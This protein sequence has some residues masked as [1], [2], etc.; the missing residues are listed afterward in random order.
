MRIAIMASTVALLVLG[1]GGASTPAL[2]GMDPGAQ[3]EGDAS[4]AAPPNSDLGADREATPTQDG[5][6]AEV[7]EVVPADAD[8]VEPVDAA[9]DVWVETEAIVSDADVQ[10]PVDT[11]ADIRIE[12]EDVVA[13]ADLPEDG[14][15]PVDGTADADACVAACTDRECGDDGCGG[16][17][18]ACSDGKVCQA[19]ACV[20]AAED[21]KACCGMAVC[22]FDSCGAQGDQTAACL[23]GCLNGKCQSCAPQ[24]AGKVCGDDGCGGDCGTCPAGKCEALTWT[25]GQACVSGACVG[26]LTAKSCDDGKDCTTDFCDPTAGCSS[27]LQ[28][29]QCLIDGTCHADG[30]ASGRCLQCVTAKS[31]TAWTYVAGRPCND[32]NPCTKG[33]ACQAGGTGDAGCAGT[34]YTCDDGLACTTDTCDGQGGCTNTLLP[35][36]C[37]IQGTCWGDTQPN[38][39]DACRVCATS[40]S[41]TAWSPAS[42]GTI[43]AA[44]TCN[45]ATFTSART[46]VA[47]QCSAGGATQSC[48]DGLACTTDSCTA[49]GCRNTLISGYCLIGG[50]CYGNLQANPSNP[51][52]RCAAATAP[53]SWSPAADGTTCKS[54]TCSGAWWTQ[55]MTCSS[56]QCTGG[57]GSQ[58]CDDGLSCTTDACSP[59]SGCSNTVQSDHCLIAG[60][61]HATGDGNGQCLECVPAVSQTSWTCVAKSCNDGNPGTVNDQC[62]TSAAGCSC[63]G[64]PDPCGAA[65]NPT[66]TAAAC[67]TTGGVS[68][69]CAS[70]AAMVCSCVAVTPPLCTTN[71][72]C[73]A[74]EYCAK[75][76][77]NCNGK[78][79][80]TARPKICPLIYAPVCG[81]DGKTYNNSC[82]AAQTGVDVA[83]TGACVVAQTCTLTTFGTC[84]NTSLSCQCCPAGGP[85][86]HCVCSTTCKADADC[87][88]PTRPTCQKPAGGT[89]FCAPTDLT[90]C[91]G[92]L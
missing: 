76:D 62:V 36:Y 86:E 45:G 29:G 77:G 55:A 66:C 21:H 42:D 31:T 11:P 7:H 92:C 85:F 51:C 89:G 81:C 67:T 5:V 26:N 8:L 20:C 56:G 61:C 65:L 79:S 37:D 1:C 32:G 90:C 27:T 50:T 3:G 54:G 40:G 70:N 17:C 38:P 69:K 25:P 82:N 18:G 60:A 16:T 49:A 63:Q 43:C 47:G 14:V 24:C 52:Q 74:T 71:G 39:D 83:S 87:T 10:E 33:D 88:D 35:G 80:C 78:G 68:G 91:W 57:G 6:S 9:S 13:D 44:A 72:D 73:A 59:A 58:N 15:V 41:T 64:Q 75:A 22:W 30:D 53:S 48:D 12:V 2:Q 34:P 19:G 84:S 4:D 28:S 46:C 23:Y